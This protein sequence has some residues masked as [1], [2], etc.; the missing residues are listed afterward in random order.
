MPFIS[1]SCTPIAEE[2]SL[3]GL[4]M[5]IG[6]DMGKIRIPISVP[7]NGSVLAFILIIPSV[8]LLIVCFANLPN[9][10]AYIAYIA[11]A[12]VNCAIAF[13][14]KIVFENRVNELIH[15][16]AFLGFLDSSVKINTKF[17]FAMYI[18]LNAALFVIGILSLAVFSRKLR[19][20]PPPVIKFSS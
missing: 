7:V 15:S 16:N 9:I 3:S 8:L 11:V 19:G 10:A 1:V 4:D 5:A 2:I 18:A 20:T 12:V 17:G 6:K 14:I 13:G